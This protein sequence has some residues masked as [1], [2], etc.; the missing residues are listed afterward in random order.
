MDIDDTLFQLVVDDGRKLDVDGRMLI[1]LLH[2][3]YVM[4]VATSV[5]YYALPS[6]NVYKTTDL[7]DEMLVN[8]SNRVLKD[9]WGKPKWQR[10]FVKHI[11]TFVEEQHKIKEQKNDTP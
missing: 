8:K 9:T 5:T 7:Y 3:T 2:D 6:P 10:Q 1:A 11:F 4:A